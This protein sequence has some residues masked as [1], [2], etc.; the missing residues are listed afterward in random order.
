MVNFQMLLGGGALAAAAFGMANIA[1]YME[2]F[3]SV[4]GRLMGMPQIHEEEYPAS[5]NSRHFADVDEFSDGLDKVAKF[6]FK[7]VFSPSEQPLK[8]FLKMI[9]GEDMSNMDFEQF[10]AY[11]KIE[12]SKRYTMAGWASYVIWK[13][14][15]GATRV[16]KLNEMNG[17]F[18]WS[19]FFHL[20]EVAK[21]SGFTFRR[22]EVTK[23]SWFFGFFECIYARMHFTASPKSGV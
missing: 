7:M 9:G 3:G 22:L 13:T 14:S 17:G 21:S 6:Y 11:V 10:A 8:S 2:H 18:E 19:K 4:H 12:K 16:A 20:V 23:R 15:S 1:L 5:L